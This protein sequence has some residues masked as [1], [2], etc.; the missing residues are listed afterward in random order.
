VTRRCHA[1]VTELTGTDTVGLCCTLCTTTASVVHAAGIPRP[2]SWGGSVQVAN[3]QHST[4]CATAAAAPVPFHQQARQL[5]GQALRPPSCWDTSSCS[6]QGQVLHL[7]LL[8][9]A[10]PSTEH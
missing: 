3:M 4:A 10:P 1:G 8:S 2:P 9:T 5:G 7:F 6:V